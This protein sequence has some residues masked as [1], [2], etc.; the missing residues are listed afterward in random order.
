MKTDH[1]RAS[2]SEIKKKNLP[3]KLKAAKIKKQVSINRSIKHKSEVPN[4]TKTSRKITAQSMTVARGKIKVHKKHDLLKHNNIVVD[5]TFLRG[6]IRKRA[7][8]WPVIG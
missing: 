6:G 3:S 7:E 2:L 1:M 5:K 8:K 4:N